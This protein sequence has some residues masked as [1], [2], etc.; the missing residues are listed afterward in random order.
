[1]QVRLDRFTL[2]NDARCFVELASEEQ[3]QKAI[4]VLNETEFM[5]G[6]I[7]AMPLKEDF[8]WGAVHEKDSTRSSR[9]FYENQM[10][11]AEALKPLIEGRRRLLSV[12]TPGWLSEY[13][14]VGH[15]EHALKVIEEH[16]GK[17]GIEAISSLQP[18]YGD[19]KLKPRMLCSLDFTSKS[20][21]D[22]ATEALHD[23]SIQDRKIWLQPT[24]MSPWRAHQ[25]GKIDQALLAELQEKGLASEETYE[26]NFVKS[27][28]KK[29]QK[30][31][32]TT[33]AARVANKKSA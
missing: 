2:Q 20:G 17:Y 18:F 33:R 31:Y 29:G 14:S 12:Q 27:D 11:P 24:K 13:S 15:N 7:L 25:V 19:K 1:L 3:A 16:F 4:K 26:D 10:S 6:K 21:A 28:Q 23:T 22:Q 9:Y 32:K 5:H 30:N 8:V